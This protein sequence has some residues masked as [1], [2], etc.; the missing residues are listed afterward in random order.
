MIILFKGIQ[1]L[2]K[3]RAPDVR[4]L[5]LTFNNKTALSKFTLKVQELIVGPR[6][7]DRRHF[8]CNIIL[9]QR[10]FC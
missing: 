1:Y 5:E 6:H 9:F 4:D 3:L 10:V 2:K 7:L 8:K